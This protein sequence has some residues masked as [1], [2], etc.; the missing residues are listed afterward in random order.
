MMDSKKV[1]VLSYFCDSSLKKS[2]TCFTETTGC[3]THLSLNTTWEL[4]HRKKKKS[5]EL[6][7]NHLP[8]ISA[9]KYHPTDFDASSWSAGYTPVKPVAIMEYGSGLGIFIMYI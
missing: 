4:I 3:K 8:E 7:E 9:D 5:C 2:R 6:P 1:N